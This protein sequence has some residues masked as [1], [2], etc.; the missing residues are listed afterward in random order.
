LLKDMWLADFEE[1]DPEMIRQMLSPSLVDG[2]FYWFDY[3]ETDECWAIEA[4]AELEER[5]CYT[6]LY[7]V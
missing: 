5:D 1:E 4:A 2:E 6:E 7:A 3:D